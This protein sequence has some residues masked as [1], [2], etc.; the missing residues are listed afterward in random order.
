MCGNWGISGIA[1][2]EVPRYMQLMDEAE[3]K[4]STTRKADF[5]F[6]SFHTKDYVFLVFFCPFAS[7]TKIQLSTENPSEN[8]TRTNQF[9][10]G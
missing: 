2:F 7:V 5:V 9:A 4:N 3:A 1:A 10:E 6:I 8:Y